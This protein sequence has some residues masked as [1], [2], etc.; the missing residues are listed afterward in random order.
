MQEWHASISRS[1][2]ASTGHRARLL[3][4]PLGFWQLYNKAARQS[5]GESYV[6]SPDA[7]TVIEKLRLAYDEK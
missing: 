1:G 5:K 7:M 4:D 2:Q 3:G 6:R